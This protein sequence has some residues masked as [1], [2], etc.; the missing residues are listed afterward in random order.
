ME[1]EPRVASPEVLEPEVNQAYYHYK[2][3]V[4]RVNHIVTM[5]ATGDRY[6]VYSLQGCTDGTVWSRPVAEWFENVG[7]RPRF[8]LYR[9]V[10]GPRAARVRPRAVTARRWFANGDHPG[11]TPAYDD[12]PGSEPGSDGLCSCGSPDSLH[13]AI[14]DAQNRPL[15]YVC[16]GE[17][18]VD[19][20][21]AEYPQRYTEKEFEQR[22]SLQQ[23]RPGRPPKKTTGV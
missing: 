13:G 9:T 3:G 6:V 2:G 17:W 1:K 19:D 7:G 5:E 15:D 14:R 18:I 12:E 11:V 20:P 22:F 8:A 23:K 21:L 4:Y 10:D 16:P